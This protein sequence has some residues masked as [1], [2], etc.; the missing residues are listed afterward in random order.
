MKN[1]REGTKE[2][3]KGERNKDGREGS[4]EAKVH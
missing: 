3:M 1:V 2:E 4:K